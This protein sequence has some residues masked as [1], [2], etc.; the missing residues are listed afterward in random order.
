MLT[1]AGGAAAGEPPPGPDLPALQARARALRLAESPVWAA[2][3]HASGG[4]ARIA[5]PGFL[6]SQPRFD[7]ARELEL[8]I[9]FLYGPDEG[10]VCRFPARA[11]WLQEEGGFPPLP[12]QACPEVRELDARA[13]ADELSLAFASENITVPASMLGHAFLALRGTT[14]AGLEVEHAVSFF[15]DD[16]DTYNLPVLFYRAMIAGKRGLFALGPLREQLRQYVEVEQRSLWRYA[17]RLDAQQIERVRMHLLELKQTDLTYY[18]QS[19]NCATL[20][21]F[22]LAV[23]D[24]SV[25]TSGWWVTPAEV[26]R[27]AR[28]AGLTRA[29]AVY[30]PSRTL[31]RELVAQLPADDVRAARRAVE[32]GEELEF[33]PAQTSDQRFARWQ[34]ARAYNHLALRTQAVSG[35]QWEATE[36]R[37][38][39]AGSDAFAGK[40]L[41]V[42]DQFDPANTPPETHLTLRG[43]LDDGVGYLAL[44]LLPVSHDIDDDNRQRGV[45]NALTLFG[46]TVRQDLDGSPPVLDRLRIYGIESYAPYDSLSG[47]LSGYFSLGVERRHAKG[48]EVAHPLLVRG[49]VGLAARPVADL[50]AYLTLGAEAGVA[51][52]TPYAAASVEAGLIARLVWDLKSWVLARQTV[53]Y[54]DEGSAHATFRAELA[55]YLGRNASVLLQ[56][57]HR[58][59]GRDTRDGGSLAVRVSY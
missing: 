15:T 47:G 40:S 39:R 34:L 1:A 49:G 27:R 16:V 33:S 28:K 52:W 2:L 31:V 29:T 58:R 56:V 35:A 4:R 51:R 12:R 50:D 53:A 55:R 45:E 43:G 23:A 57:E 32:A 44:S 37:L 41:R 6:L 26:T 3:L 8:T 42:A 54:L 17:L 11:L 9:A 46:A 48:L 36:R 19:Y 5:D 24:P 20:I 38:Q 59:S 18:F 30:T 21:N 22:V 25:D 10:A 14:P 13:P 7:A